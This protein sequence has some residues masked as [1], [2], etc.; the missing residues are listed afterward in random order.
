M[1]HCELTTA[2]NGKKID[3]P[4]GKVATIHL[5]GNPTTGFTWTRVGFEKM[6]DLSDD[7]LKF[8]TTY[9]PAAPGLI[10]GGGDFFIDVTPKKAG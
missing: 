7:N 8:N 5:T 4:V 9:K 3:I 2:D 1:P 6:Q 10:G